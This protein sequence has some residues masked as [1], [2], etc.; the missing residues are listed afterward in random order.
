ML[1]GTATR[2]AVEAA[3]D[4]GLDLSG[5]GTQPLTE[6]LVRHADVIYV[7]TR[8]HRDALVDQWP[9]AAERT[10]L[11]AADGSDICDPIGGPIERYRHCLT[12]MQAELKIRLTALELPCASP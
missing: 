6:P 3:S 9:S 11:L 5:H 10:E 7:M 4:L 8:A 2:E 12:R 1:G